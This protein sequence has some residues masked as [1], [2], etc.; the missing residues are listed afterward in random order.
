MTKAIGNAKKWTRYNARGI[1]TQHETQKLKDDSWRHDRHLKLKVKIKTEKA[2]FQDLP[3]ILKTLTPNDFLDE[4]KMAGWKTAIPP[5][6]H[7]V[8][9][10]I[11]YY[12]KLKEQEIMT[13]RLEK[14]Q[15]M[16]VA[17]KEVWKEVSI[18]LKDAKE[19]IL[20]APSQILNI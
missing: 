13:Y 19:E 3:L 18:T 2:L 16:K 9:A 6:E 20:K 1:L 7:F 15:K 12:Y 11:L 4:T 17:S 10:L 14:K 8:K 5:T